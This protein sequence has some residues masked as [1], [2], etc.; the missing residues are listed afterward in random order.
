MEEKVKKPIVL[1]GFT[2]TVRTRDHKTKTFK[3]LS[4]TKAMAMLCT[5]CMGFEE[6]PSG[7]TSPLCPIFPWR[8]KTLSTKEAIGID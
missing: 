4:R 5:E 3:N 7:C 6:E 2:H 1:K 8:K